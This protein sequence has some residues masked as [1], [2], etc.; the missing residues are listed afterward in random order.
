MLCIKIQKSYK[1]YVLCDKKLYKLPNLCFC[2]FLCLNV[3]E[4]VMRRGKISSLPRSIEN[5][6]TTLEIKEYSPKFDAAAPYPGPI[7]LKVEIAETR[8][9]SIPKGSKEST[10]NTT[11][12]QKI[13]NAK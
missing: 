4:S 7:L 9:V 5:E 6:R 12:M 3:G 11:I 13:Y 8:L 10:K 2:Y 1:I